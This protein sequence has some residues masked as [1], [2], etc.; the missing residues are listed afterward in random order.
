MLMILPTIHFPNVQILYP[1][2]WYYG[3]VQQPVFLHIICHCFIL[4]GGFM[5]TD[6]LKIHQE[7]ISHQSFCRNYLM[8]AVWSLELHVI[9]IKFFIKYQ[10]WNHCGHYSTRY[11]MC[12]VWEYEITC[13]CWLVY[14]WFDANTWQWHLCPG[15][16]DGNNRGTTERK[17]QRDCLTLGKKT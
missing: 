13:R 16:V 4:G 1:A 14:C 11:H 8:L 3:F 12:S 5:Q 6:Q 7:H 15:K 2:D 17:Q 9:S 10:K